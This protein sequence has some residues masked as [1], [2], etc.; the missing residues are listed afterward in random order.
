MPSAT[1]L[2]A[3]HDLTELHN[4]GTHAGGHEH[5]AAL[6]IN[7]DP[8]DTAFEVAM[9]NSTSN[10]DGS[11]MSNNTFDESSLPSKKDI[12]S[13]LLTKTTQRMRQLNGIT[14]ENEFINLAQANGSVQSIISWGRTIFKNDT[15]QC[16]AFE[17]LVGSFVLSF[18][19]DASGDHDKNAE[20]RMFGKQVRQLKKLVET[21]K[22]K[23]DQLI[24]L[25]H[26]PG[27]S[28]K[29]TVID[30]VIEYAREY[31]GYMEDYTFTSRTIIVTAMTGVAATILLGDT[32]HSAVYLNQKEI[33]AE[34][35][36]AW[37][38]TRLLIIDEISFACKQDFAKLHR[39]LRQL[40]Q[41]LSAKY[42]GLYVVFCGDMRQLEQVGK[43]KYPIYQDNC[44]E[45]KEWV[46]CFIE[47][48]G[49]HR[50]KD[51]PEWGRLLQR[52]RDG[53]LT[54]QDII[55]LNERVVANGAELPENIRY[56]TYYNRDRDAINAALFEEHCAQMFTMYGHT[57]DAIMVF[58]NKLKIRNGSKRYVE[59][60]NCH[61]F[62]ETCGEDNIKMGRSRGRMDPVLRLYQN[63]RVML[64]TNTDVKSGQAYGTQATFEKLVLKPGVTPQTILLSNGTPVRGCAGKPS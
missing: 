21:Q 6:N 51:D 56:A 43:G 26:G 39:N 34:Q 5:I 33:K 25:L 13:I 19:R 2:P 24:C 55:T 62:W 4:K 14:K 37:K 35:I 44:P 64:P 59:L 11:D 7:N 58:S 61:H 53:A 15:G 3:S 48:K 49:L 42:G 47:L 46:N 28:G 17:I 60:K 38:E 10:T 41:Q 31:C 27:G 16:R 36:E 29:T 12:V 8:T 50:F 57:D 18:Y 52:M 20:R 54:P 9:N 63:C 30:V 1:G 32:T 45:F 40:K 22:R 23:S